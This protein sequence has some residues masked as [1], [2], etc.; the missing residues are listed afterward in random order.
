M[1]ARTIEMTQN[2]DVLSTDM[3]IQISNAEKLFLEKLSEK[4]YWEEYKNVGSERH[5]KLIS[6][7][8]NDIN[9][10]TENAEKMSGQ[11]Q[12]NWFRF[13]K[14]KIFR[15]QTFGERKKKVLWNHPSRSAVSVSTVSKDAVEEG[16][17]GLPVKLRRG[18]EGMGVWAE[19]CH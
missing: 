8:Q 17:P 11:L 18:S 19:T 4:E 2:L 16:I 12:E 7:L 13:N 15:G 3:R 9:R 14:K 5:A 1:I 10:V 6:S